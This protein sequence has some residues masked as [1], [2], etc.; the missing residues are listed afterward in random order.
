MRHPGTIYRC[1]GGGGGGGVEGGWGGVGDGGTYTGQI[2]G[3][4]G[5]SASEVRRLGAA[6]SIMAWCCQVTER[7]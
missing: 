3:N 6:E 5:A 4:R 7:H 1:R 2:E